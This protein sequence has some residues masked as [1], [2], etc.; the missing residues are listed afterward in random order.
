MIFVYSESLE[1]EGVSAEIS[2]DTPDSGDKIRQ[3][4][5]V[6]LRRNTVLS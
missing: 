1:R 5:G 6:S 2:N 3:D 4:H